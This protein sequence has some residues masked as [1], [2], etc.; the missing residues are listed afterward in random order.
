MVSNEPFGKPSANA[1]WD[2]FRLREPLVEWCSQLHPWGHD[3][4]KVPLSIQVLDYTVL[5]LFSHN[6]SLI[7][8]LYEIWFIPCTEFLHISHRNE[9][10]SKFICWFTSLQRTYERPPNFSIFLV[11][12][13]YRKRLSQSKHAILLL[14]AKLCIIPFYSSTLKVT[15]LISYESVQNAHA[16][17]FRILDTN[18]YSS[19]L[20]NTGCPPRS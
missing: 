11:G 18:M 3:S 6:T 15:V 1:E 19:S 16:D 4:N 8:I 14:T 9:V 17:N 20:E 7:S 13:C 2:P 10:Y 12:L 5:L